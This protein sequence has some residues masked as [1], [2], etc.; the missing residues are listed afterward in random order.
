MV[1]A[2]IWQRSNITNC[3]LNQTF[4][5]EK[6]MAPDETITK[7]DVNTN[8]LPTQLLVQRWLGVLAVVVCSEIIILGALTSSFTFQ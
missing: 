7:T 1:T 2:E 8:S 5:E 4:L 6:S 3:Q